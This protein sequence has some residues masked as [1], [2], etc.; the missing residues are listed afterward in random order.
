MAYSLQQYAFLG[1]YDRSVIHHNWNETRDIDDFDLSLEA[2]KA[3]GVRVVPATARARE[4]LCVAL[5][6]VIVARFHEMHNDPFPVNYLEAA[7]LSLADRRYIEYQELYRKEWPGPIRQPLWAAVLFLTPA[8]HDAPDLPND[9]EAPLIDLIR[10][11]YQVVPAREQLTQWLHGSID[12]ILQYHPAFEAEPL[13]DLFG[14]CDEWLRGPYISG[15]CFELTQPY[16]PENEHAAML[17]LLQNADTKANNLLRSVS[18]LTEEEGMEGEPY[19][20][21]PEYDQLKQ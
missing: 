3:I 18:Y 15:A 16:K 4:A 19:Q 14:N 20:T 21:L 13:F 2:A 1:G 5:Y 8:L 17:K 10:L 7:W 11:A 12:R 9:W 6:E